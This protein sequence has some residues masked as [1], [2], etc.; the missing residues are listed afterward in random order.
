MREPR[1]HLGKRIQ[2][3]GSPPPLGWGWKSLHLF[4]GWNDSRL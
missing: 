1:S 3:E 4:G 2:A